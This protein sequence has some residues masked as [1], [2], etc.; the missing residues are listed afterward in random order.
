MGEA[1]A[2]LAFAY[3][4]AL[5]PL[6][7]VFAFIMAAEL[8]VTHLIVSA[9]WTST[10]ALIVSA[11][12][13][14]ALTWTILFARSLK[15][16]PVLVDAEGVTMRIGLLKSVRVPADHI[17]RLRTSWSREELKR[18]GVLNFAMINYPNIMLELDPPLPDGK[19]RLIAVTHQFDDPAGFTA[20]VAP[21]IEARA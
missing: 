17:A 11:I 1:G 20:A 6:L 4:R 15:R 9:V 3:H 16:R 5:A 14:A 2:S 21:L 8:L 10:A 7:W 13:F 12:S 18:K 19:R